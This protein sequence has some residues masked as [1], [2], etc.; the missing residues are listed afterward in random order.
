[1]KLAV[2]KFKETIELQSTLLRRLRSHRYLSVSLLVATIVVAACFHIWQRVRVMELVQDVATL[3]KEQA[4]LLDDKKKLYSEIASLSVASR[5]ER[6]ACDTLGLRPVDAERLF[7]LVPKKELPP[8]QDEL[9]KMFS[10]I[11]RVADHV[12]A[13]TESRAAAAGVENLKVDTMSDSGAGQ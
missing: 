5:I 4:S 2:R 11:R 8:P 10:A 7:T 13:I 9:V 6:Y 1:M 3:K 12:P